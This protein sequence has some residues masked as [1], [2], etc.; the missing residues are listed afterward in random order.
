MKKHIANIITSCRIIFSLPLLLIPLSSVWFLL[1]LTLS[2]VDIKYSGGVVCALATIAA[3]QE[4]FGG[5]NR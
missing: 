2:V 3:V 4:F 1:P 5:S